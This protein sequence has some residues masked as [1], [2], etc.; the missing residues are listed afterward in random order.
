[1]LELFNI[2]LKIIRDCI[3]VLHDDDDPQCMK[4][5]NLYVFTH[6]KHNNIVYVYPALT[7]HYYVLKEQKI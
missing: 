7:L 4:L 6:T 3:S 5:Q 2:W 1:M